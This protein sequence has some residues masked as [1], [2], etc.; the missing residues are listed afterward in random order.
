M[1]RWGVKTT[2]KHDLTLFKKSFSGQKM[3]HPVSPWKAQCTAATLLQLKSDETTLGPPKEEKTSIGGTKGKFLKKKIGKYFYKTF[4]NEKNPRKYMIS[5]QENKMQKIVCNFLNFN[6][7]NS[8]KW[9]IL[10]FW[11]VFVFLSPKM[12]QNRSKNSSKYK[13]W[14]MSTLWCRISVESD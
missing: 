13:I 8:G 1:D 5:I 10:I 9:T 2:P 6:T 4:F 7:K 14:I 12:D 11:P 3:A